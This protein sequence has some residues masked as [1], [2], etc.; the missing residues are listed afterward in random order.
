[1]GKIFRLAI[2]LF[3]GLQGSQGGTMQGQA[4]TR[5]KGGVRINHNVGRMREGGELGLHGRLRL[6]VSSNQREPAEKGNLFFQ[7]P[8]EK[9]S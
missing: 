9:C 3:L 1:M 4:T 7:N 2:Q 8:Q 6:R 5:R